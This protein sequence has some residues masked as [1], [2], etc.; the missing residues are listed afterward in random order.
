MFDLGKSGRNTCQMKLNQNKEQDKKIK[1]YTNQNNI[2]QKIK[3][4]K[5]EQMKTNKQKTYT[6]NI[7]QKN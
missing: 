1:N 2:N 4:I 3:N 6:K 5:N 7:K